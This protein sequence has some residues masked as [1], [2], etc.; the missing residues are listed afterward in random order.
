MPDASVWLLDQCP[1]EYRHVAVLRHHPTVLAAFTRWHV[2][3]QR[4]GTGAAL[5]RARVVLKGE[6][7]P[8]IAAALAALEA[9]Q[10]RLELVARGVD[11]LTDALSR[12][13]PQQAG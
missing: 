3:A 9:E 13:R 12:T 4:S 7:P 8:V 2:D 6:A 11:A 10:A 5:A 1:P